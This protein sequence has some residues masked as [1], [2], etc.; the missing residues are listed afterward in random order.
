MVGATSTTSLS[1]PAAFTPAQSFF[2]SAD[3]TG[4]EKKTAAYCASL[5]EKAMQNAKTQ[6]KCNVRAVVTDN[7]NKMEVMR[8]QLK[9][10]YEDLVVYRC[11]SHLL[12]LLGEDLTPSQVT[13]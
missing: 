12:N 7:E 8:K 6:F 11:S 2:V 4:S 1:L 13:K 9:E 10:E 3:V 5:A